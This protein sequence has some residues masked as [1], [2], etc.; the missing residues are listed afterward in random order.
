MKVAVLGGMGLQGKAALADLARSKD[1]TEIIC[2]DLEPSALGKMADFLDVG[3]VTPVKIDAS[4]KD[5]LVSVLRQDVDVAIDLLPLPLMPNAFDAAI[6]A[7]VPLVS[8]N[9]ANTIRHLHDRAVEAGVSLM[10]ECGLDPGIDLIICGHCVTQFDEVYVLNSYCGGFPETKACDNP[11]NYKVTWNWDMVLGTQNRESV[12]IK[13]G[14]RLTVSASDQHENAMIHQIDFPGLGKLE[15]VPN[16]DAVFYTDLLGLT[17]T[18]QETRRYA[19]RWPGW[20]AFWAP[21]KKLGF[22]SDDPVDGLDFQVSPRQFL[23]KLMGPQLQYR[24]DEKDIVAMHNV[25]KGV[26]DGRKKSIVVNLMIERDLDTGLFAMNQGVGYPVSI[27]ARMMANKE[28]ERKGLLSPATDIPYDSFMEQLG[29]RGI[30]IDE[31]EEIG[32]TIYC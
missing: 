3:R 31:K 26:K 30:T 6:E 12:F 18:I 5:S 32:E 22:L 21:L 7:G 9:Y 24:D 14:R 8:T 4:S 28:I 16:G 25:F 19:L 23:V 11:L 10:P 1:V 17:D 20:C 13:D 27:V 29:L 2:A 15:A